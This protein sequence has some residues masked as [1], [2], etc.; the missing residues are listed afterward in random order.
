M[1]AASAKD[2]ATHYDRYKK[3]AELQTAC[4]K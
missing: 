1:M 2:V 3:L 4:G